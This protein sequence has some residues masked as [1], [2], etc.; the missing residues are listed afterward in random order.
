MDDTE[1]CPLVLDAGSGVMKVSFA[2]SL[3]AAFGLPHPA[4]HNS[5]R[6]QPSPHGINNPDQEFSPLQTCII[7]STVSDED[8][9][10]LQAG[11]AGDDAPR[12]VFASI[13]GRPRSNGVTDSLKVCYPARK[14]QPWSACN[15]L[16]PYVGFYSHASVSTAACSSL[17]K[18][19][20]MPGHR[21]SC[22]VT[23]HAYMCCWRYKDDLQSMATCHV[24][25]S[26]S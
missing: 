16:V 24:K 17:Q 6:M 18:S 19:L 15:K 26:V 25:E 12:T 9:Q 2:S 22:Q 5:D 7:T 10:Q 21:E 1:C 8:W 4:R 13:I 14:V 11:I 20:Q 3:D 23:C